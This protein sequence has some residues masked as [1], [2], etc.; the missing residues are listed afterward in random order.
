M[1]VTVGAPA[2]TTT[3]NAVARPDLVALPRHSQALPPWL[4]LRV[5]ER[6]MVRRVPPVNS[7]WPQAPVLFGIGAAAILLLILYL[8]TVKIVPAGNVGVVTN[9]GAVQKDTLDPGLHVVMPFA[10]NVHQV[11]TQVQAHSFQEIDA[12]SQELQK[13]KLTGKV[14]F[15]I[16][17]RHAADLYQ[18]VGLDFAGKLLDPSFND[19]IKTIVPTYPVNDILKNRDAIRDKTKDR[20]NQAVNPYGITIVAVQIT[21]I[22]FS[23]EFEK[24]IEAK[25]VAQQQ[26]QTQTQIL[27]QKKIQAQQAVVDAEGQAK[28]NAI[29]NASLTP[30]LVQWQEILKWDGKLPQV[31]GGASPF[32]SLSAR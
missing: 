27:E 28:A 22:R 8:A 19:F 21:D 23:A 4:D 3:P 20:L 32:V 10:Q 2:V 30:T 24:A 26:V 16:D 7:G 25:Q 9:F 11:N 1:A 5:E 13:V 14:N 6:E 18:N 29:L 12:A 17:A 31:T 15:A